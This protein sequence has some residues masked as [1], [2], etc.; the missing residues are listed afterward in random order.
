MTGFVFQGHILIY[1]NEWMTL[2]KVVCVCVCV[3]IYTLLFN[4]V[5]FCIWIFSKIIMIFLRKV[6]QLCIL[7]FVAEVANSLSCSWGT[8]KMVVCSTGPTRK[9]RHPTTLTAL[10][11]RASSPRY[12]EPVSISSNRPCLP[13]NMSVSNTSDVFL[14]RAPVS[15]WVW[16]GHAGLWPVQQRSGRHPEWAHYAAA[17]LRGAL[18]PV[19]QRQVLPA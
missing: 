14:P 3:C 12:L 13:S 6:T 10:T 5:N 7:P 9:E 17:H 11:R 16:R 8:L 2:L 1:K 4:I 19:G 15:L 18:R